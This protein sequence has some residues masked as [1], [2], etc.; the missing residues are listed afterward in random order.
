L[1]E[2]ISKV[3]SSN[4]TQP[5]DQQSVLNEYVC[6][7]DVISGDKYFVVPVVESTLIV[8]VSPIYRDTP[9]SPNLML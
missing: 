1:S 5:S 9:K 4:K 8:L 3:T 6:P 7:I 2:N